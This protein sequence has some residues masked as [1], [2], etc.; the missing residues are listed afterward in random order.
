MQQIVISFY[1]LRKKSESE[2]H[3]KY[4]YNIVDYNFMNIVNIV[5]EVHVL[6][7]S[8]RNGGR[9]EYHLNK[10]IN[11]FHMHATVK[12]VNRVSTVQTSTIPLTFSGMWDGLV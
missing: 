8:T 11:D 2:P 12:D 7:D 3:C 4:K 10:Y 6:N 1:Y 5:L 9:Q